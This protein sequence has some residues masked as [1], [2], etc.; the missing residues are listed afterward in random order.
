MKTNNS[1]IDFKSDLDN[2][3]FEK[4]TEFLAW[5]KNDKLRKTT[6]FG[7]K[8]RVKLPFDETGTIVRYDDLLWGKKFWVKI[9]KS[10]G[11]N[12]TNQVVDFF[13]KHLELE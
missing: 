2:E 9:R 10:N 5:L 1:T 13:G 6:G 8:D 12:E 7:I 4:F 3:Q 11:F